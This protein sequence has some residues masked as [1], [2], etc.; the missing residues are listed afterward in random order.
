M[1]VNLSSLHTSPPSWN[2]I[3]LDE[4]LSEDW[5]KSY[6]MANI[7]YGKEQGQTWVFNYLH[8]NRELFQGKLE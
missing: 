1:W 8:V 5:R 3:L 4:L 6:R 7:L 2:C